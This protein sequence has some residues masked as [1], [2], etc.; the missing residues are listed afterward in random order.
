MHEN[1]Q[2][3]VKFNKLRC[4][5]SAHSEARCYFH[6]IRPIRGVERCSV[7][8]TA[9]TIQNDTAADFNSRSRCNFFYTFMRCVF[10]YPLV[11]KRSGYVG[12]A[13]EFI[14]TLYMLVASGM[15]HIRRSPLSYY[16]LSSRFFFTFLSSYNSLLPPFLSSFLISVRS[17]SLD[18]SFSSFPSLSL[19]S[20]IFF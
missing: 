4:I 17:L 7:I 1:N 15:S 2:E 19:F 5:I 12:Q 16:L 11:V 3:R 18:L 14:T 10:Q 6:A 8:T 20:V 9:R 13:R